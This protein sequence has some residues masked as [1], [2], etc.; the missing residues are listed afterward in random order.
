MI[1]FIATSYQDTGLNNNQSYSYQVSAVNIFG[2]EGEKSDSVNGTPTNSSSGE[3]NHNDSFNDTNSSDDGNNSVTLLRNADSA[4]YRAKAKGRNNFQFFTPEIEAEAM[5]RKALEEAL[6]IALENKD[7][8]VHYQPVIDSETGNVDSVEALIRW[9]HSEKGVV[10]PLEFI[11]LAEEIGLIVPI[12]EWVLR[13]ACRD[14]MTW[15]ITDNKPLRVAV[16]LSS[17]QFQARNIPD[18]VKSALLE[19]GLPAERLTL[20]ITESLLIAD[21]DTTRNQLLEIRSLGVLLSIDDFGTGYSSLSY[22]KKF[23]VT[24]LKI[25]RSFI[26]NL[27]TASEDVALVNAILSM[28][29]S[30][31][32]NVIAEGV[33]TEAQEAF[34]KSTNCQYIQ[35]YLYSKPLANTDFIDY[36]KKH[37]H[38][39]SVLQMVRE[40]A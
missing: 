14:A 6:Y 32:L 33:E 12:G 39:E 28:A 34:M 4:M 11:P 18:L 27:P 17:R 29:E 30:L 19:T 20:E 13:E 26:M 8:F 7:F 3:D 24:T 22:L 21:N 35:G 36:L 1:N 9:Q 10:S 40:S 5:R 2:I 23:P 25:D 31:G 38:R 16:N 15:P 37:S